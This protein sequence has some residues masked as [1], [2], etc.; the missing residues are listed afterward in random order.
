[1]NAFSAALDAMFTDPN[2]GTDASYQAP[3]GAVPVPCRVIFTQPDIDFAGPG[4]SVSAP[5]RQCDIRVSEIALVEENGIVTFLD[6]TGVPIPG[7]TYR[8]RSPNRPDMRRFV[9]R[10]GLAPE[11]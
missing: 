5:K 9:W 6:D 4:L 2:I 3:A 8:V 1:M 10:F 11:K 7:E